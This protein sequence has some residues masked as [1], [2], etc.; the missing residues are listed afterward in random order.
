MKSFMN[1]LKIMRGKIVIY[2][3][4]LAAVAVAGLI[5]FV[6]PQVVRVTIDSIIGDK[7]FELPVFLMNIIEQLGGRDGLREKIW[8]CALALLTLSF[9]EGFFIFLKGRWSAVASESIVKGLRDRVY[10]HLQR[11]P[12]DYHVKANTGD[13]VQRCTTDVDTIRQFLA[14][15]LVEVGRTVIIVSLALFFMFRLNVNMTLISMAA[16]PFIFLLSLIFFFYIKKHFKISDEADGEMSS[17]LQ[18]NLAGVRVVRAFA[19]Q[20]YETAKFDEKNKEYK[21]VTFHLMR[22]F[23]VYWSI[24]DLLC[25]LQVGAVLVTGAFMA[26]KGQMTIG[27]LVV[28]LS[29]E[30]MLLWPIRQLGRIISD[31]GKALVAIERIFEILDEPVEEDSELSFTPDIKGQISFENVSFGYSPG[32]D[33]LKDLSFEVKKGETVAILGVTGSGKS[34]LVHLLPRLYDYDRGSIKIDG[35]ELKEIDKSWIRDRVGIVLQEPFLYSKNIMDNI[36]LASRNVREEEIF[37]ATRTA[38]IH[39]VIESFEKGY[40]TAVGERGFT[41]S[42]GQKQRLAIARTLIK[43]CPVLIFDDSL[44]AVDT[45]TDAQIRM[46]LKSRENR[47]TTIIISH[48][49]STLSEADRIFVLDQGR[50][51]QSG[52]HDELLKVEGLYK[53]I[54]QIQNSLEDEMREK[55]CS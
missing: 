6:G 9:S 52:T 49:V 32:N 2:L 51:I 44:S 23:A 28:F 31:M 30:A 13:L 19:R 34:S 39:D 36:K 8:L 21:R 1:L 10:N 11:L 53:R 43:N 38:S 29:Y 3:A 4:A 33:I 12:F 24:S 16:I 17:V 14:V 25:M 42:G 7:P 37:E 35:M 22:L 45:E 55:I 50:L 41:L 27:T 46:A 54:W 15:Q 40:N 18:E 48:R 5:A 20:E 26:Y 47:A